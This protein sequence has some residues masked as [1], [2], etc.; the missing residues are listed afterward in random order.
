MRS[1]SSAAS[2]SARG[3]PASMVY[4]ARSRALRSRRLASSLVDAVDAGGSGGGAPAEGA[5]AIP[6]WRAAWRAERARA[7][8]LR[9]V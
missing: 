8:S 2:T 1:L 3:R 4:H 6:A 7:A 9:K 5:A